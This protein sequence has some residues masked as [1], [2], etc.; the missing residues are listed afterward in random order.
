M[1]DRSGFCAGR[2]DGMGVWVAKRSSG[3]EGRGM[4]APCYGDFFG[5][6]WGS[7]SLVAIR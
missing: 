4:E 6:R 3:F 7:R 1:D 5:E 2:S